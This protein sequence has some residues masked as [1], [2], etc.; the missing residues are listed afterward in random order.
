LC[1]KTCNLCPN[2]ELPSPPPPSPSLPPPSPP[3]CADEATE[4]TCKKKQCKNYSEEEKKLCKKTCNLCPAQPP[5]DCSGLEKDK[6]CKKIKKK[7]CV[8]NKQLI[9]CENNCKKD[10]KKKKLC[11]RTCCD[12]NLT[13]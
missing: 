9:K 4:F 10:K 6:K 11:T 3:S 1:K 7:K 13:F 8:K 12:L 5:P 2:S